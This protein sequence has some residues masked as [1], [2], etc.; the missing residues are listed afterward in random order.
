MGVE[1]SKP[2]RP[3]TPARAT[4][5]SDTKRPRPPRN[6]SSASTAT[7]ETPKKVKLDDLLEHAS[8]A[9]HTTGFDAQDTLPS[10]ID[11][12]VALP[13]SPLNRLKSTKT[14]LSPVLLLQPTLSDA[15]KRA[16]SVSPVRQVPA[17][18][19]ETIGESP[20]ALALIHR[21]SSICSE[22]RLANTQAQGSPRG[23]QL[24]C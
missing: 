15:G 24:H 1:Q 2:Q 18:T 9:R 19:A 14:Q 8:P 5:S 16:R 12:R 23:R 13:L 3:S 11:Q 4:R 10:R 20:E 22:S 17:L 6:Q 7:L 21:R